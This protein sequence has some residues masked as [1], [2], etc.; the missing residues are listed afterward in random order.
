MVHPIEW[1]PN[2]TT[3]LNGTT[4]LELEAQRYNKTI[5]RQYP[6]QYGALFEDSETGVELA[7]GQAYVDE[8]S[9]IRKLTLSI[10][11]S[12]SEGLT[13]FTTYTYR[14]DGLGTTNITEPAW[15]RETP[16]VTSSL[17][18][19]GRGLELTNSDGR[20]IPAGHTIKVD[21]AGPSA[22]PYEDSTVTLESALP[23]GDSVILYLKDPDT[24]SGDAAASPVGVVRDPGSVPGTARPL[25]QRQFEELVVGGSLDDRLFKTV[26]RPPPVR[27]DD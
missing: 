24:F 22:T 14:L 19:N 18:A 26:L 4:V 12:T 2:G 5:A 3:T 20:A 9:L 23:P 11:F 8:S 25:T 16:H 13:L 10:R 21:V 27:A 17:T 6:E 15:L 1:R 7:S